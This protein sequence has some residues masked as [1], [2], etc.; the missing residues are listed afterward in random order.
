M[1][2]APRK[3]GNTVAIINGYKL[4][5]Y[6]SGKGLSHKRLGKKCGI[7][8]RMINNLEQ[9]KARTPAPACFKSVPRRALSKLEHALDCVGRLECGQDD[10]LLA[11]YLMFYKVNREAHRSSKTGGLEF[12]PRTRAAVFDFGGTLTKGRSIYSTWE[13]MWLSVGYSV[14]DAGQLHRLYSLGKMTHQGWCDETSARLRERGF[15]R[16]HMQRLVADMEP[17]DD[18]ESTLTLLHDQGIKLYVVSGSV[19][20]IVVHLLGHA[21]PLFAEVKANEVSYDNDG[22]ISG[23]TGHPYDFEGKADFLRR[24]FTELKCDPLEVLFVGNSLNDTWASRSGARTLCVNPG[25][26]DYT[27]TF[28]WNDYIRDVRS[29]REVLPFI[30]RP[31]P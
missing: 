8:A 3:A 26:V 28:I 29:L 17:I 18:L 20:E 6:R 30:L 11:T 24:V 1:R 9:V 12:T 16:G 22:I 10:D 19:R 25:H 4:F 31:N 7:D 5:F 23:I 15:S 13:R 21:F 14:A 27:N 2:N